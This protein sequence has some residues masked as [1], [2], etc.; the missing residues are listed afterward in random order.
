VAGLPLRLVAPE[1]FHAEPWRRWRADPEARRFFHLPPGGAEEWA[2]RLAGSRCDLS[3]RSD[4]PYRWIAEGDGIAVG[5]V[6]LAFVEWTHLFCEIDYIIAPE[7]R[8][9]GHGRAMVAAAL[10]RAFAGGLE[11]VTACICTDNPASI[12]LVESLGFQREALLRRH[13]VIQHQR[14][15][16]YLYALLKEEGRLTLR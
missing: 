5:C 15:D 2:A 1:P 13:A 11:R 14:R 16:H 3:H 9:R 7:A 10:D 6:T 8:R 4:G 12:R